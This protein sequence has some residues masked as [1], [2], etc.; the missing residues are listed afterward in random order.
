MQDMLRRALSHLE[1]EVL[2]RTMLVCVHR[3]RLVVLPCNLEGMPTNNHSGMRAWTLK[4]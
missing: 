3:V 2:L 4:N 1:S